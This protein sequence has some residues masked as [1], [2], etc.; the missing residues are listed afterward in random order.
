MTQVDKITDITYGIPAEV[1]PRDYEHAKRILLFWRK[2]K[3]PVRVILE[4]GQVFCM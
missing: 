1:V 3:F 4:D 2:M